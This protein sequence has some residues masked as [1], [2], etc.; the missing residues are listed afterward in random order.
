LNFK[1]FPTTRQQPFGLGI[2]PI[3]QVID[4][5]SL[6]WGVVRF[7]W[8]PFP[9]RELPLPCGFATG[10]MGNRHQTLLGLL[11][12]TSKRCDRVWVPLLLREGFWRLYL[13][14]LR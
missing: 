10:V 6:S 8:F 1:R 3:R 5:L 14:S 12:S 7:L 2:F 13:L 11:R 9:T 4:S